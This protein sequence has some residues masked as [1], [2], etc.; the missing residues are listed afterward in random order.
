MCWGTNTGGQITGSPTG[1][2]AV[3]CDGNVLC[4]AGA[5]TPL[6][7]TSHADAIKLGDDHTCVLDAGVLTCWGL[8]NHGQLGATGNPSPAVIP[9]A[10]TGLYA[11]GGKAQC[12]AQAGQTFCWGSLT[13]FRQ[14]LAHDAR[15]DNMKSIGITAFIGNATV[16]G[17][18]RTH[19]CM[20]GADSL[21]AC[22]GVD[23]HGQFGRGRVAQVCGNGICDLDEREATC[24]DCIGKR[25]CTTNACG[26]QSCNPVCGD[27]ACNLGYGETCSTCA[28]DCGACPYVPLTRS[29]EA[30]AVNVDSTTGFSCAIRPDLRIECWGRNNSGQAGALDGNTGRVI[31][32]VFTPSLIADLDSCSA[33]SAGGSSACAIC[34]GEIYCWGNH[35]TGAVGA[36]APTAFPITK[37]RKLAIDLDDGDQW[38]QLV[39]GQGFS[40]ARSD[41]GRGFC[42]GFH[43]RGALGTGGVS[44]NLPA[45]IRTAP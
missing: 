24:A 18:A 42:W 29:Y 43:A 38:A 5:P 1:S 21:L 35:R 13:G 8:N 16:G 40:C 6:S 3:P 25:T 12:A 32:P 15:F 19:G 9:G 39:S 10:W 36:G 45:P 27:G 34:G 37:P 17:N 28:A 31:D 23:T 4:A 30:M 33:V 2:T 20:L 44:L 11:T 41:A 22:F 7:F 26:V 14:P